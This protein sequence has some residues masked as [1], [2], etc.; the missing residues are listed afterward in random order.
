[1]R[2]VRATALCYASLH[3]GLALLRLQLELKVADQGLHHAR[4]S[5]SNKTQLGKEKRASQVRSGP[6]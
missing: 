5:Q 4:L 6:L 1:M 3:L 2:I